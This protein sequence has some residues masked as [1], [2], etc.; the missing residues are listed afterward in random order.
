MELKGPQL[1]FSLIFLQEFLD[2]RTSTSHFFLDSPPAYRFCIQGIW[3]I[4]IQAKKDMR[5]RVDPCSQFP[6]KHFL[7]T[8]FQPDFK[9]LGGRESVAAADFFLNTRAA[10]SP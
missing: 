1:R 5:V 7:H 2:L 10:E 8:P 3:K 6:Q 9:T 4:G